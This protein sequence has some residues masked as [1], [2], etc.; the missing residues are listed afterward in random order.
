MQVANR[1]PF[2]ITLLAGAA[3]LGLGYEVA[4][5]ASW[6]LG[7]YPVPLDSLFGTKSLPSSS[8]GRT[9]LLSVDS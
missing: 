2:C 3:G 1:T 4:K 6:T 8:I 7:G 9:H 5:E